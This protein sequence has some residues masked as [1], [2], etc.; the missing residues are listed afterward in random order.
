MS[1]NPFAAIAKMFSG[2]VKTLTTGQNVTVD[3]RGTLL[4]IITAGGTANVSRVDSAD[5]SADVGSGEPNN[6][7]IAANTRTTVSGLE[8]GF[9]RIT[10]TG[11]TLRY[12]SQNS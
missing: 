3:A 4:T 6:T 8:W 1:L 12:F 2:T 11:G 7:A 5:A 9:Y 10:S